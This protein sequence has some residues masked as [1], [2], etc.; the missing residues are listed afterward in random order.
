VSGKF[1]KDIECD[2]EV[3]QG[4]I[5]FMPY[6]FGVVNQA[7]DRYKEIDRRYCYTTPKSFLELIKLFTTMYDRKREELESNKDRLSNGLIKLI[8]T[9]ESVAKLEADLKEF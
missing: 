4:I 5:E 3:R 6:S 7:S 2:E 8:T 9:Q 1:L